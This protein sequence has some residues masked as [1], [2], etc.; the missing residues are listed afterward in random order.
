[1]IVRYALS[2]HDA[3]PIFKKKNIRMIIMFF[4]MGLT[5]YG[6]CRKIYTPRCMQNLIH[7]FSLLGLKILF[8]YV[9]AVIISLSIRSNFCLLSRSEEHTSEL[10]SR[11]NLV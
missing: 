8:F 11:E 5:M 4:I 3:L 10:Q 7:L 2:L 1:T 6:V 9:L